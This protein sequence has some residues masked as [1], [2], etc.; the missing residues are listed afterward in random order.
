MKSK[1]SGLGI[2]ILLALVFVA[3]GLLSFTKLSKITSTVEFH[4]A[5][6]ESIDEKKINP[7]LHSGAETIII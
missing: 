7:Y 5:T 2:R 6:I 1:K 3:F 4:K